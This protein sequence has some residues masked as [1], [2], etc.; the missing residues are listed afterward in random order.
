MK[1]RAPWEQAI[2]EHGQRAAPKEACG[3]V[4]ERPDGSLESYPLQNVHP[5][6]T[7]YFLLDPNEYLKLHATGRVRAYYHSHPTGPA[8]FS[9]GDEALSE[10]TLL[11]CYLYAVEPDELL[12]YTP[13]GYRQPLEGR[14]YLPG[15]NDC[16]SLVRDYY[17]DELG[18]ELDI[19]L[20]S[21]AMIQEGLPDLGRV[22]EQNKMVRVAGTPQLHDVLVMHIRAAGSRPNHC[23]VFVGSGNMLHQHLRESDLVPWGGQW[24]RSLCLMLRHESLMH[25]APLPAPVGT[26]LQDTMGRTLSPPAPQPAVTGGTAQ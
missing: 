25:L 9:Q 26:V 2:A 11:P 13:K 23:G 4:C 3:V 10:E 7:R 20:R 21:T 19:P 16:L 12:A 22:I 1:Q 17:R 15:V 8:V 14:V 18:V 6:P 24:E 5:D